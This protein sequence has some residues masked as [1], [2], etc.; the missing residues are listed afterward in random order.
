MLVVYERSL[1]SL[2][3]DAILGSHYLDKRMN[4]KKENHLGLKCPG[5]LNSTLRRRILCSD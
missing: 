5:I 3:K 1:T 4:V 2:P